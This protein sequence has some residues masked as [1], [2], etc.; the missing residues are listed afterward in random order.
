MT[1]ATSNSSNSNFL[2]LKTT[3]LAATAMTLRSTAP[4]KAAMKALVVCVSAT[5]FVT[6]A[7]A[8]SLLFDGFGNDG[9]TG[10]PAENI[11]L[12]S[13]LGITPGPVTATTDFSSLSTS[14]EF[15]GTERITTLDFGATDPDNSVTIARVQNGALGGDSP[16]SV[17]IL[18]DLEYDWELASG[19][20]FGGASNYTGLSLVGA[21]S[22]EGGNQASSFDLVV[23]IISASGSSN[24]SGSFTPVGPTDIDI[25]FA[26]FSGNADFANALEINFGF[27]LGSTGNANDFVLQG[28]N[29]LTE[30]A[31][32][33]PVPLPAALPM[34]LLGIGTLGAFR[35]FRES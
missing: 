35:T 23:D 3:G 14:N 17:P 7:V 12:F 8:G 1:R 11:V 18:L 21:T 22:I 10:A 15:F 26:D 31:S 5:A 20:I 4:L 16:L 13:I 32:I 33:S 25:A 27:T 9:E 2:Q 34:L 30:D 29:V 6:P 24:Y 28:I 19:S